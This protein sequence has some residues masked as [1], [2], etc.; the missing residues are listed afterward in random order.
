M[1]GDRLGEYDE[2]FLVNLANPSGASLSGSQAF[3]T[4]QNDEPYL[5]MSG[6]TVTEGN[7][8]TRDLTFTVSLSGPTD[9]PVTASFAT[10]DGSATAGQDYVATSG[11]V[12]IARGETTQ[13]F[14]VPVNGDRVGEYEEYFV[15]ILSAVNGAQVGSDT[16]YGTIY[17]D[18]PRI[19]VNVVSLR[20]GNSGTKQMTFTVRLS[21]A[22]DQPVTVRYATADGSARAG[23]DYVAK[24]GTLTFATGQT[25][26]TFSVTIKG[27]KKKE[28]DEYFDIILSSP[29]P[30][31]SIDYNGWGWIEDDDRRGNR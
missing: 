28:D 21:M 2:L 12:T 15:V 11:T 25:T 20:E 22:Y 3:G 26:K 24:S 7:S 18:E 17:D 6:G 23:E 31:A 9:E 29:S 19:N 27:D 8:G 10:A 30:N 1:I 4:I 13:T 16:G 5:Y 14:T